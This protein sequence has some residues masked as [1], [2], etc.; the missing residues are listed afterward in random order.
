MQDFILKMTV[1]CVP[2]LIL[3]RISS[4]HI[5]FNILIRVNFTKPHL[6]YKYKCGSEDVI[7]ADAELQPSSGRGGE[8]FTADFTFVPWPFLQQFSIKLVFI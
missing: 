5:Y 3:S 4:A 7:V 2:K 8:D 6:S 1:L